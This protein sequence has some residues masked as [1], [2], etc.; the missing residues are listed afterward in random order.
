VLRLLPATAR[1]TT[2]VQENQFPELNWH[3]W[4]FSHKF[5]CL[6]SQWRRFRDLLTQLLANM[7]LSNKAYGDYSLFLKVRLIAPPNFFQ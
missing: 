1:C 7:D 6:E 2:L 4:T 5:Y 3:I